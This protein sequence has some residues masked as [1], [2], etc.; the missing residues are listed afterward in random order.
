MPCETCNHTMQRVNVGDPDVYWC[1]TC[2]TI[3]SAGMVPE[4]TAPKLVTD[5]R[6]VC[7]T[8]APWRQPHGG[9]SDFD[10]QDGARLMLDSIARAMHA[11]RGRCGYEY[12]R[13]A[14]HDPS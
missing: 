5:A 7:E 3:R 13:K 2:G 10:D 12:G 1:K 9:V 14:Q 6:S 8:F 11:L 4:F